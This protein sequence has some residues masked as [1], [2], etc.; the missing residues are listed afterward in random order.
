M[1]KSIEMI[2]FV[3]VLEK[4]DLNEVNRVLFTRFLTLKSYKINFEHEHC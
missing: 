1:S 3:I 2:I 4:R